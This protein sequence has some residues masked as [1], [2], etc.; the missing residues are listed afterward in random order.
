MSPTLAAYVDQSETLSK[1]V[2]LGVNLSEVDKRGSFKDYL[3]KLDFE[4]D[5]QGNILFLHDIGIKDE[6]LGKLLTKNPFLLAVDLDKLTVRRG[7]LKE[8][9]FTDDAITQIVNRAPYFLNFS[10][11]RVDRKLGFLQQELRLTGDETRY[12]VTRAPKLVTGKIETIKR[13]LFS[14]RF[15][16]RFTA[17]ELKDLVLNQPKILTT[18]R[19]K[20][21]STFDYLH[22]TVGIKHKQMTQF[23]HVFRSSLQ[24]FKERHKYLVKLG[25]AQYDVSKPGYVSLERMI[26]VPDEIFCEEIAK[27]SIVDFN[28][29]LKTL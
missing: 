19:Y 6:S 26:I 14:L 7:Y 12:L 27:S 9:K 13:N 16:L 25:R 17:K 28:N 18:G 11:K 4:R 29:F 2:K 3:V 23:P 24:K 20:L 8:K 5:I 15:Q 1:L 10:I 22:N 21:L